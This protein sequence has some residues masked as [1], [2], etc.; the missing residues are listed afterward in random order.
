MFQIHH[1]IFFYYAV[2]MFVIQLNLIF[3]F[4]CSWK[5]RSERGRFL[6]IIAENSNIVTYFHLYSK[7]AILH[8]YKIHKNF[9][10]L[11]ILKLIKNFTFWGQ[12][13]FYII[14]NTMYFTSSHWE[15]VLESG[16]SW[17][18]KLICCSWKSFCNSSF[19]LML[20]V[21]TL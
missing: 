18:F 16:W 2:R 5:F 9:I 10:F 11:S 21:C 7:G 12:N 19:S 8:T 6:K 1:S 17:N 20:Q 13:K 14:V 4:Q 3:N 15:G